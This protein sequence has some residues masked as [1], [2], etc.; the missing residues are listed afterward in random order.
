MNNIPF[1]SHVLKKGL[2]QKQALNPKYSLRAYAKE[3]NIHPSV[4]SL[5]IKGERALTE[6]DTQAV[7]SKLNLAQN[8]EVKFRKSFKDVQ[9]PGNKKVFLLESDFHQPIITDWEYFACLE[10]FDIADFTVDA[11]N[12]SKKLNLSIERSQQILNI[13]LEKELIRRD[14]NLVYQKVHHSLATTDNVPSNIIRE[15]HHRGL[16]MAREKLE[17]TPMELRDYSA[18]T[19][20]ID[21]AKLDAA[22]AMISAFRQ[23]MI[24]FMSTGNKKE[25]YRFSFQVFPLSNLED[26]SKKD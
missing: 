15:S 4:L 17:T 26:K 16:E 22:K 19:L 5:A 20:A 6:R 21:P 14:E 10:L 1:Y 12:V 11:E 13:L 18:V 3:L 24:K 23:K 7:L 25:V 9:P 8:E 2:T